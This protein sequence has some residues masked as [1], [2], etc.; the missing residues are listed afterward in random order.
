MKTFLTNTELAHKVLVAIP[1]GLLTSVCTICYCTGSLLTCS[2]LW[3]VAA[4][5]WP[6][7]A[8]CVQGLIF[9]NFDT[10][11]MYIGT[12]NEHPFSDPVKCV[13]VI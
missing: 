3:H 9:D 5:M 10:L 13:E 1:S 8:L 7:L 6:S 12:R 4:Y 2:Y 11:I